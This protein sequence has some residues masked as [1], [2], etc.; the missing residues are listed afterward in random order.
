[1]TDKSPENTPADTDAAEAPEEATEKGKATEKDTAVGEVPTEVVT[2][3][4]A[5]ATDPDDA[6]DEPTVVVTKKARPVI[7]EDDLDDEYEEVVV[8]RR[9][10]R[11]A[12]ASAPARSAAVGA[13]LSGG[14][15][16]VL[17][18]LA[19]V[20]A[21]AVIA[22]AILSSIMWWKKDGDL[23]AIKNQMADDAKAEQVAGDYAVGAATF[24]YHDLG[25]WTAA[26]TNGVSP[27][28]KTKL[29]ATTSAMNQLLQ[30]LQ[31]VSK[32]SELDAVVSSHNGPVYKVN[33]YVRVDGTNVQ[34]PTGR[35]VNVVYNVTLNKDANWQITDVGSPAAVTD[36]A[37]AA[38]GGGTPATGSTGTATTQAP[39]TTAPTDTMAPGA[40]GA[41]TPT[42]GG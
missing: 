37:T 11:P 12:P 24:D 23:S 39:A 15:S 9:K 1:M 20:V 18:V 40:A 26:L 17:T 6:A 25:P 2:T 10:K 19:T 22:V 36:N 27:E 32:A 14:P 30:P 42:P 21:I 33:V 7:E 35:T 5:T 4:K 3:E 38:Q 29:D 41:T 34:T 13:R 16:T 8:R 31:W 28:L